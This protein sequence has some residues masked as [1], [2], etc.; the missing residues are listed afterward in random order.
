MIVCVTPSP[1]TAPIVTS[2]KAI[3]RML[4]AAMGGETGHVIHRWQ[5][6]SLTDLRDAIETATRMVTDADGADIGV[7]PIDV[8]LAHF[9]RGDG[10]P[11]RVSFNKPV[12]CDD[13]A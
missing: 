6:S 1:R 9:P 7:G 4:V 2:D 13:D 8:V 11:Y 12:G 5:V 3:E 10:E